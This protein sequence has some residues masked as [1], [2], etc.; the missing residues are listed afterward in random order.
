MAPLSH[1]DFAPWAAEIKP[2][3]PASPWQNGFA[4]RII[5]SIRRDCLDHVVIWGE[6]HCVGS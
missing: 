3:A 1:A 6:A 5:G 2:I 4:E